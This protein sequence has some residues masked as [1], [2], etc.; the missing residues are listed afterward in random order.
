MQW[1][2]QMR[3]QRIDQVNQIAAEIRTRRMPGWDGEGAASIDSGWLFR[4]DLEEAVN[5]WLEAQKP[6][7]NH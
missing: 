7:G 5:H 2:Q 1:W 6:A 3:Q 4:L